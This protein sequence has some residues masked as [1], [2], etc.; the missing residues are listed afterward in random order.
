MK[1]GNLVRVTPV[2]CTCLY[3]IKIH[4]NKVFK[5]I[6]SVFLRGFCN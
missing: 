6:V 1:T 5:E 4:L 3:H 2:Y